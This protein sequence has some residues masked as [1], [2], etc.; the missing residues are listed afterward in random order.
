NSLRHFLYVERHV[1]RD[2]ARWRGLFYGEQC[3]FRLEQELIE[4]VLLRQR[5]R[6]LEMAACLRE[7]SE[8]LITV[9]EDKLEACRQIRRQFFRDQL[10]SIL[11]EQDLGARV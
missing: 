10:S 9:T 2:V 11:L 1:L 4:I 8:A 7:I 3:F 6:A 5:H